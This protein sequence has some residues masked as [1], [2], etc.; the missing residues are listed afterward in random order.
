MLD[1]TMI[2]LLVAMAIIASAGGY[3]CGYLSGTTNMVEL[4]I[5]ILKL[6]TQLDDPHHC[7][8]VCVEQFETMGC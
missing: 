6:Q 2:L 3:S 5:Q 1:K 7:V 8:S 4:D